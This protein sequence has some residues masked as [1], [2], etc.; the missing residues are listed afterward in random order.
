MLDL[1]HDLPTL[2]RTV[3]YLGL[4]AIVFAETGLL[5][6]FFLPGDSLL[7]TAGLLSAT[8]GVLSLPLVILACTSAAI[9]GDSVGYLIGAKAGPRI[10]NRPDSR[11]LKPEHVE[12]AHAYFERYGAKTLVIA[13]FVPIVRTFAPTM[14]GVARMSYRTFITYNVAGGV[15]WGA[16]VPL[17]GYLLGRL[18]PDLERYII[19]LIGLVVVVSVIPVVLELRGARRA[20]ARKPELE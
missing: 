3:S 17:A 8:E 12:R 1:L 13:R 20:P 9:I 11:W 19:L 4:F 16:G 6:G 7:I 18:I 15:L 10:F 14:A 2:I 5:V